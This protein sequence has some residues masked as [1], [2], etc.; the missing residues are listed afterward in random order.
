MAGMLIRNLDWVLTLD[1]QRRLVR[2]GAIAI[3]GE[4]IT[5]VGPTSGLSGVEGESI[6]GRGLIALPG[7]ID[8]SVA[9]VQ[10]L[11]RGAGDGC[12]IPRYRLERTLPLEGALTSEDARAAASACQLEMIRSGTTTFVDTGSRF[13]A[14]VAA[15]AAESGLR[16]VVPRACYDVAETFIGPLPATFAREST[17]EALRLAAGWIK[18]RSHPAIALPWLA[19]CSDSL[20]DQLRGVDAQLIIGAGFSRDDAVASRREH[21][22][23]ELARLAAAGLLGKR[24]LISHGGWISPADMRTLVDT[25]TSVACCPAT[26]HRL[27]TGA[28]EW[29]RFPELQAFGLN[30]ALG[31]GSAMAGNHVDLVRQL[32]QFC[33][34]NMSLRLDATATSPESALEMA[35]ING[36]R[37]LG[38]EAEIGSLAQGKKAD[39]ALFRAAA[40]DWVPMINPVGNLA[41]SARGGA[42]TVIANG[43]VLMRGGQVRT[44]DEA[45]VLKAVQDRADALMDRTQLRRF[46]QPAWPVE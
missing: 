18:G 22:R 20:L 39:I 30:V 46:C 7:L 40:V 10:H 29:G 32:F 36:A 33:G 44:L 31:S 27:G 3:S 9:S 15:A 24:T 26:S 21:H 4:R 23:T 35:T 37:A 6:D 38:L 25:G 41:F 42:D 17:A 11:G 16:G 12:D 43:A 34:A 1:A 2:D 14:E 19:A 8:A 45:A 5:Y 28:L 13:P